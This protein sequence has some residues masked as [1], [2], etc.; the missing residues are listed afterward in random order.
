MMAHEVPGSPF[1]KV[2][3]DFCDFGGK[4]YLVVKDYFSKW[5]EII[6]TKTKTA[7][8][9]VS[10]WRSLFATF[11]VPIT[12]VAD[13]QPFGSYCC[14]Q[15]A[16][17][18][19]INLVTSSPYYPK[20]NGMAERAVQTAKD[21]LRKSAESK[22]HYQAALME[23]RNTSLPGVNLSPV[24]IMFGRQIR[25]SSLTAK[26]ATQNQYSNR[27]KALLK[28]AQAKTK[29]YYDQQ[30][31]TRSEFDAG[32][33][34]FVQ[35]QDG[36]WEPAQIV[37]PTAHPRSYIV[38]NQRGNLLRRNKT[39]LRSSKGFP[40]RS[41]ALSVEESDDEVLEGANVDVG[42]GE[43]GSDDSGQYYDTAVTMDPAGEGQTATQSRIASGSDSN[44]QT[45]R[46]GRPFV[47]NGF[48]TVTSRG[49]VVRRP[50]VYQ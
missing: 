42:E 49:R 43:D 5:L 45:A 39:H 17:K 28:G 3:C 35:Q 15:Y 30:A 25:T 24:Q 2:G 9:V 41:R 6:E 46:R 16:S 34:V 21:I 14:Q 1:E 29:Q 37:S 20:S 12:I 31:K 48:V 19:E 13:N 11:G 10:V 38:R 47:S 18:C 7:S 8:E 32:E 50:D 23:Y 27:V 26:D 4:S 22:V 44:R 36:K 40:F 33:N